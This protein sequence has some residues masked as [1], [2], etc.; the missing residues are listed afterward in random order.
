M[1][2][3]KFPGILKEQVTSKVLFLCLIFLLTFAVN[4]MVDRVKL[5]VL[6]DYDQEIYNQEAR[7]ELG[8]ALMHR[9]LMVEL[10]V[11]KIVDAVDP[12]MVD[13]LLTEINHSLDKLGAILT[14]LQNG[15]TFVN[16]FPANFYDKDEVQE[17]IVFR[18]D[19]NAGYVMEVID[20]NPK[21]F[22]L[23]EAVANI[24]SK[25]RELLR[26][27]DTLTLEKVH[28]ALR[29]RTMQI[30][31]LILRA[32][33]S[34]SK[35]FYE[36]QADIKRLDEL[37]KASSANWDNVRLGIMACTLPLSLFLFFRILFNIRTIL[38]DR[39]KKSHNLEEAK[40][41]I[42]KIVDSIPVGMAIVNEQR[43]ILRV[44]PE[45][46]RIFDIPPGESILGE[47]CEK[48]FC[49][50]ASDSC[51]FV[52][53][54]L[55]TY[56][57]EVGIK[58]ASGREITVIKKATYINLSGERVILEAFMDISERIEIEKRLKSQ[59]DYTNA[60]LQGVQAGVVV[61]AAESHTIVDMNETAARLIGVDRD[62]AI[63]SI[64][65]EYICPAEI[66]KCPVTD[67]GKAVDH[68]VRK[69]SNGKSILK[70]VVPFKRGDDTYLLENFVDI[71][72][73]V[74]TEEQ[75]KEALHAADAGSRA[76]SEFL[77]RMSH[78]FRTP[79][80]AIMGFSDMLLT[81]EQEPLSETNRT[82]VEYIAESGRFLLQMITD[83]LEYSISGNIDFEGGHGKTDIFS[84][85]ERGEAN[86][87]SDA[88]PVDADGAKSAYS[89]LFIDADI[90][91][92]EVMRAVFSK[93][94]DCTLIVRKTVEK[95]MR[96]LQLLNPEIIVLGEDLDEDSFE[97]AI[98]AIQTLDGLE[99]MPFIAVLGNDSVQGADGNVP[100]P[101]DAE[102]VRDLLI[103]SKEK[104]NG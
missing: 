9:L 16:T 18:R 86:G 1:L 74:Q 30:D 47:R 28:E 25:M 73:Q 27:R 72:E 99:R 82:H 6:A 94:S 19:K 52:K 42:E 66:G 81:D 11:A 101:V 49:L 62:A 68:A 35:I 67:L 45:A 102:G 103:K 29:F 95:G 17:Q 38:A 88:L 12:R 64:C 80:N 44:N 90:K 100:T 5:N 13:L 23:G 96:A 59:Q 10:G 84:V 60:V 98:A 69:L 46:L 32:R 104:I 51:P 50:S 63:G 33:E 7:S 4:F 53:S 78:E 77:S 75:L 48:V 8:K 55:G 56:K 97:Q 93:S 22:E 71:T 61:I 58:T 91:N 83:I 20:L 21:I 24:A 41:A 14:I 34:S 15:G 57:N 2:D 87:D 79:L 76:K 3:K 85:F 31:A 36:T 43:K 89:V 92:I 37:K 26:A 39:E 54:E 40:Q 65:H 70:S